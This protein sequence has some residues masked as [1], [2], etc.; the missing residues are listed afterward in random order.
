MIFPE[1]DWTFPAGSPA[2]PIF[3]AFRQAVTEYVSP[4]TID[5]RSFEGFWNATGYHTQTGNLSTSAYLSAVWGTLVDYG[6][7]NTFAVPWFADYASANDGRIPFVAPSPN[8][9]WAYGR[10]NLTQ[11]DYDEAL[12]RKEVYRTFLVENVIVPDNV[13]CSSSIYI[14]PY[15]TGSSPNYRVSR[16]PRRFQSHCTW[17]FHLTT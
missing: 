3:S 12:R 8:T 13:T 15:S 11:A 7:W 4:V 6:Q 10:V 16:S 2:E 17:Y 5:N 1:S 9:R 14:T